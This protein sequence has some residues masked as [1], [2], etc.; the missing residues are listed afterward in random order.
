M[1]P[2]SRLPA[3]DAGTT[4]AL[5][6][7]GCVTDRRVGC[8]TAPGLLGLLF[9]L[10]TPLAVDAQWVTQT[11]ELKAGWN[12]VYLHVNPDHATISDLAGL[13]GPI[14]EVSSSFAEPKNQILINRSYNH[15]CP[16]VIP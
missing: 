10:L 14:E 2:P 11:H 7:R 1:N 6:H 8:P 16:K 4:G 5:P 12:A 3:P 9:L 13:A 15:T